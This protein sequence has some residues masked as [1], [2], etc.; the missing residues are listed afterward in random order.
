MT[1]NSVSL[2]VDLMLRAYLHGGSSPFTYQWQF[3]GKDIAGATNGLLRLQQIQLRDAGEYTVLVK[4]DEGEAA[5]APL[6]IEVDPTF[7]NVVESPPRKSRIVGEWSDVNGDGWLDLLGLE[8]PAGS[9]S[10]VTFAVLL[11]SRDGAFVKTWESAAADWTWAPY[12]RGY[13]DYDND[14]Q[15]DLLMSDWVNGSPF[16]L[17]RNLG[18]GRFE[19]LWAV[20]AIQFSRPIWT[21]LNNDGHLDFLALNPSGLTSV[22]LNDRDGPPFPR[23][24]QEG[25]PGWEL[26]QVRCGLF[27]AWGD[28]DGDGLLDVYLTC[29]NV[30]G[31]LF[32]NL[33]RGEFKLIPGFVAPSFASRNAEWVDYDNDGD[34]DLVIN[35]YNAGPLAVF[36][37]DGSGALA[38]MTAA[39]VGDLATDA[40]HRSLAIAWG[41]YDNDGDL[42]LY[43][44]EMEGADTSFAAAPGRLYVNLGN[45]KFERAWVGT[46]TTG[47]YGT[48][49]AAS[50]GDY[51]NDGFLDLFGAKVDMSG[52]SVYRNNLPHTGNANHW[53]KIRCEGRVSN[54]DAI[55][56]KV[57]VKAVIGGQERWQLRQILFPGCGGPLL[58]HFGLGDAP[59]VDLLRVE[60]PS[61]IVQEFRDLAV[62]QFKT[63]KEPPRLKPSGPC[64]FEVQCWKGMQFTVE[65][66]LDLEHWYPVGTVLNVDGTAT[67]K[68]AV[69]ASGRCR[70]YRV[71][72]P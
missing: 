61:G 4:N 7:I 27:S 40:T 69:G 16:R 60:W 23:V 59:Q 5:S 43:R 1:D 18:T 31:R 63:V 13:G 48:F 50:W 24:T 9:D 45:G 44:T 66:S 58:A 38:P 71:V 51:D 6:T 64:A 34:L 42:D 53:L 72:E 32:R 15:T 33:G 52:S 70:F 57:R 3:A 47:D 55:G 19:R 46:P 26:T 2:G 25:E 35:P 49:Y 21:D 56:A 22:F 8:S 54:R 67:F 41:D 12:F 10:P 68:D 36:R 37:N 17:Y 62:D 65:A 20:P 30:A 14:G 39:E 28:F 11:N 29:E